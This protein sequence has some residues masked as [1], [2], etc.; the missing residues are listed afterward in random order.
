[1]KTEK[2]T[3]ADASYLI[4]NQRLVLQLDL[5]QRRVAVGLPFALEVHKDA[6]WLCCPQGKFQFRVDLPV[7]LSRQDEA[8]NQKWDH[9]LEYF[10]GEIH[11]E[12]DGTQEIPIPES[13]SP[14]YADWLLKFIRDCSI[15]SVVEDVAAPASAPSARITLPTQK[16]FTP[17]RVRVRTRRHNSSKKRIR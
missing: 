13:I 3:D 2:L 7:L 1:M 6:W 14:E 17:G 15:I 12:G 5:T 11:G 10:R 8:Q 4:T 16:G 9:T